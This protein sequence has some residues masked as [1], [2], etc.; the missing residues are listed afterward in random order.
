MLQAAIVEDERIF[1]ESTRD[2]LSTEFDKRHVS[3]AFDPFS[4][5]Q[6]FLNALGQHFSFDIV[7]LDIEM[8]GIDSISVCRKI[9]EMAPET[10]V[11]FISNKEELVFSSF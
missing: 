10:M 7:F 1:L 3:I 11:V 5:G 4:E 8:P 9:R 6:S 2:L